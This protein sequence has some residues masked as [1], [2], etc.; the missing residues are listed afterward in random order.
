M[1]I[2]MKRAQYDQCR[3]LKL[4]EGWVLKYTMMC[5]TQQ[6]F[7]MFFIVLHIVL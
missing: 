3:I 4:Y 1:I 5:Q 2:H 7:I 6:T